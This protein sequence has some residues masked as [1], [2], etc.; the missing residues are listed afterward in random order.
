MSPANVK[1]VIAL[2]IGIATISA[3]GFTWRGGQIGSTAS[4]N[5]RQSVSEQIDL[6]NAAVDVT[7]EA[8]RQA[9]QYDRYLADYAVA[10]RLD[11]DA[12]RLRASGEDTR[13]DDAERQ[14]DERRRAATTRAT[15]AGVFGPAV[16]G[17]AEAVS[18]TPKPFDLSERLTE[19]QVAETT[20]LGSTGDLQ[21]QKW[22]NESDE[23][24]RRIRNLTYWVG[25]LLVA[26]VLL[27]AAEVTIS[28]RLRNSGLV[29][30][31][32]CIGVAWVGGLT[33]GYFA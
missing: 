31:V 32:A 19:L 1:R 29:L 27:T 30:G 13:A 2:C 18:E 24:R 25:L 21:P 5:D 8:T 10:D 33:T 16:L 9:R 4:F 20:R 23:I 7:I 11:A 3:G 15:D 12:A 26:V 28:R 17:E 14:A 22:A 6:E